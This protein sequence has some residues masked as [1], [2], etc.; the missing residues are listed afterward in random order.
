MEGVYVD[1]ENINSFNLL[2]I[3]HEYYNTKVSFIIQ[4]T[5]YD[6][7]SIND[8][9]VL[10]NHTLCLEDFIIFCETLSS[11]KYKLSDYNEE[12]IKIKFD[13][14]NTYIDLEYFE[15]PSYKFSIFLMENDKIKNIISNYF[16]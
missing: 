3:L 1:G 10:S 8:Y 9:Y 6:Y 5:Y 13:T 4:Y 12:F 11:H 15:I 16:Q 14:R 2:K 7:Y